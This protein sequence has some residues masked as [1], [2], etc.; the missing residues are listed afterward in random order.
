M[1]ICKIYSKTRD[2]Q[3]DLFQDIVLQLWRSHN[4]FRHQSKYSTWLYR[5]A[6]NTAITHYGKQKKRSSIEVHREETHLLPDDYNKDQ[7][8]SFGTNV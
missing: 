6:I 5:I 4:R 3:E 7:E 1:N 2:E 8:G